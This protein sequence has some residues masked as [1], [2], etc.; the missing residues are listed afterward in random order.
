MTSRLWRTDLLETKLAT[1]MQLDTTQNTRPP[2]PVYIEHGT[3]LR[4]C[5]NISYSGEYSTHNEQN[6]EGG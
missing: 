5:G 4:E 3:E 2:N 1:Q 6:L